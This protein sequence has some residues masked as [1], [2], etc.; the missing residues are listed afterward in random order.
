[1]RNPYFLL[2]ELSGVNYLKSGHAS[3]QRG[4]ILMVNSQS[5]ASETQFPIGQ[6]HNV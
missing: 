1:M 4:C 2:S 6:Y 5:I 3:L